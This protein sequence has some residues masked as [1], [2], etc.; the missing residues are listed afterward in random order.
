MC[1]SLFPERIVCVGNHVDTCLVVFVI[2]SQVFI[3]IHFSL[4]NVV[5]DIFLDKGTSSHDVFVCFLLCMIRA[6]VIMVVHL[7]A[8]CADE[9]ENLSYSCFCNDVCMCVSLL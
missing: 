3:I 6:V 5:G 2:H 4:L 7:V 9:N 8:K 1:I